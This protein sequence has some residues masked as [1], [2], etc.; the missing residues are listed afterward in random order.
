MITQTHKDL[1]ER[2]PPGT[3]AL[4]VTA[5]SDPPRTRIELVADAHPLLVER[6]ITAVATTGLDIHQRAET[7]VIAHRDSAGRLVTV[8][9]DQGTE[10]AETWL[11]LEADLL[12]EPAELERLGSAIR[13]ATSGNLADPERVDS[14]SFGL[15]TALASARE[16]EIAN[17]LLRRLGGIG[18]DHTTIDRQPGPRTPPLMWNEPE[19]V[20]DLDHLTRLSAAC[21]LRSWLRRVGPGDGEVRFRVYRLGEPM[22]LSDI[23]SVLHSFSVRVV[24]ERAYEIHPEGALIRLYDFGLQLPPNAAPVDE[25]RQRVEDA[26]A[27]TWRG[28]SEVDPLNSLVVTAGL[29]WRQVTVLRGYTRFL[30]QAGPRFS[31]SGLEAA[32]LENPAVATALVALFEGRFDP[33]AGRPAA[34]LLGTVERLLDAVE[35]LDHDQILRSHRDLIMATLRTT[36]FQPGSLD[37]DRPYLAFKFDSRAVDSLPEPRPKYEIF[38]YSPR[39]E[40]IHLRFGQV[41]RGG[42]RWSDRREDFRTEIFGLVKAQI[43]KN[44][45]IVPTG[46]KGGFVLKTGSGQREAAACYRLFVSA[47]L[48]LTD[49]RVNGVVVPPQRTVRYDGDDPYLVV[50][51]DKGTATFSDLANAVAGERGFWLGDAFA[52][53]G[54]AG[55]D[56]KA[57]GITARGAWESVRHAFRGLGVDV[58]SQSVTAVGI[59]DMSGDVFGNAM[60]LSPHLQ[61]IA[62]F[63]HRSIFLDPA[64]DP[65]VSFAQRRRLFELPRSSWQDYDRTLISP[66]GGVWSRSAKSIR[67]SPE[68][69]S[70]LGLPGG[71]PAELTPAELVKAI[72]A[73][74]V[75]LLFNGGIGTYVKAGDER[76]P[77]VGDRTND[78]VRLDGRDLRAKVVCEGGNLG[79]TQRGRVEYALAGGRIATDFIDNSAGVDCSDH[80]VNIKIALERAIAT[81]RLDRRCRDDLLA[82]MADEVAGQV[83]RDNSEQAAVLGLAS[84]RAPRLLPV[85]RRLIEAYERAGHLDRAIEGLPDDEELSRRA[86]AGLGLTT[87][88]LAVLL[89]YTKI[90]VGRELGNSTVPDEGWT[91]PTLIEYFPATLGESHRDAILEHPLRREIIATGL[92]NEMVNRGGITLV[93]RAVEETGCTIADLARAWAVVREVFGLPDLW[94]VLDRLGHEAPIAAQSAALLRLRR[95]V[96]RSLRWLVTRRPLPLSVP[97]E[98]DRRRS[99][100]ARLLADLTGILTDRERRAFQD[101]VTR[102]TGVGLPSAVARRVVAVS[103][104]FRL[105]DISDLSY[106]SGH[107]I[108]EVAAVYAAVTHWSG[109]DKLLDLITALPRPDRWQSLVRMS[110]RADVYAAVIDLTERVLAG[111]PAGEL[112]PGLR[113]EGWITANA[114]AVSR[115]TAA[116]AELAPGEA[117]LAAVSV[118]VRA[119][120]R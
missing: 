19:T 14:V 38:G 59:G 108:G 32:L 8:G 4:R 79:L 44:A 3:I 18:V 53:G 17:F 77:E 16:R 116:M 82:S 22:I 24:D 78:Q 47:L 97:E 5:T 76:H 7:P 107:E 105:L 109:A 90:L 52:S 101:E 92:A 88:E 51:A 80:E 45:V 20:D 21:P 60:L 93:F 34:D 50:A 75:D 40:G 29:S 49:N 13:K 102:L 100:A 70:V 96:D 69:R 74:P 120:R 46:A 89:A 72:L 86:A 94:R 54:S 110:L 41:A 25:M 118:L 10:V 65:A 67:L 55:Y 95:L 37:A 119:L 31:R 112:T 56:H 2:R 36:A 64:P 33:A 81:G 73:A 1:A 66:G 113:V 39:F 63:D 68:A 35:S 48:D 106:R 23:L 83:L 98:I 11:T 6:V 117:D 99:E 28:D 62:A 26:F 84:Q 58:D 42:L 91:V 43:I 15:Q 9:P 87:P 61:L 103:A 71:A 85:H 12:R 111:S 57:M 104:G 27:A 115:L 114:P 30:C